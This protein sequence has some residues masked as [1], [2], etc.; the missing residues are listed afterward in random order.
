MSGRVFPLDGTPSLRRL[1]RRSPY[2]PGSLNPFE[3]ARKVRVE[4]VL[5]V[6]FEAASAALSGSP[7]EELLDAL[8]TPSSHRAIEIVP[9]RGRALRWL[10]PS[11]RFRFCHRGGVI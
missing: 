2:R 7:T 1:L 10:P 9:L 8:R 6:G 11:H 5:S 4:R 3:S